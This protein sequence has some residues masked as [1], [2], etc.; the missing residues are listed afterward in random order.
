LMHAAAGSRAGRGGQLTKGSGVPCRRRR[1]LLTK[2]SNPVYIFV[3]KCPC[4]RSFDAGAASS[5]SSP[6]MS[7]HSLRSFAAVVVSAS[8]VLVVACGPSNTVETAAS[9]V[10]GMTRQGEMPRGET[11]NGVTFDRRSEDG[12][13]VA[14]VL[15][16][17]PAVWDALV[18]ALADRKVTATLLDRPA[19]RIGDTSMVLMRRWNAKPLSTYLNC[20]S[21]MT[22]ARADDERVRAVLLAQLSRLKADTVAIAVHFSGTSTP[23][24]SGNGGSVGQ[25]TSTGRAEEDLLEDVVRRVGGSARRG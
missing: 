20:G 5:S 4:R 6:I 18:G 25:C 22:G 8:T 17:V 16:T 24:A 15:A 23:I 14:K 21:S 9:P 7:E 1:A 2:G 3:R 19:G 12:V 10:A 11:G 13:V